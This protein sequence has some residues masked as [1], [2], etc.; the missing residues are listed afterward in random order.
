MSKATPDDPVAPVIGSGNIIGTTGKASMVTAVTMI[1]LGCGQLVL[2]A[3]NTG[4]LKLDV[5][6]GGAAVKQLCS[7]A[8][9]VY[10]ALQVG[11]FLVA[12]VLP[13]ALASGMPTIPTSGS[14][15]GRLSQKKFTAV[16][17][18]GAVTLCFTGFNTTWNRNPVLGYVCLLLSVFAIHSP[19]LGQALG[20][21][22]KLAPNA[23][24]NPVATVMIGVVLAVGTTIFSTALSFGAVDLGYLLAAAG[25]M[26]LCFTYLAP[27]DMHSSRKLGLCVATGSAA[28]LCSPPPQSELYLVYISRAILSA[29]AVFAATLDNRTAHHAHTHDHSP[30][31][32]SRW[33]KFILRQSEPYPLLYSIL[34][35]SDS[36]RIFYFMA[37]VCT[38]PYA[39][40]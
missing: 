6:T 34:K 32:A 1:I 28:L 15:H 31:Q 29:A 23:V 17:I 25:S 35:E 30:A 22:K 8:L 39:R 14:A 20:S 13:L 19:F 24:A 4:A 21:D 36:R 3:S 10:A 9:P 27:V 5:V 38:T 40:H 7:I 37:Y 12:M 11:S 26:A 18:L 33:T 16:F 2:R